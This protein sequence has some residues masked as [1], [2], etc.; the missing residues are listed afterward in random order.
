MLSPIRATCTAHSILL[1]LITQ[2]IF[3]EQYRSLSSSLCSLLHSPV[4]SSLL[5][6]NTLLKPL[7]S[8]TLSVR[9]SLNVRDQVLHPYKTTLCRHS[10]CGSMSI[11]GRLPGGPS[12]STR[13]SPMLDQTAA[14]IT[15]I[16]QSKYTGMR[17]ITTIRSTTDRIYDGGPIIL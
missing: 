14:H 1:D 13:L 6:P 16:K 3:G 2:I 4:T 10:T 7:F 11:I 9:S 8:N 15:A 12:S 5:G 17:R